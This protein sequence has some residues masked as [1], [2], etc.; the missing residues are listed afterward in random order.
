M[1]DK[2]VNAT[3]EPS[4]ARGIASRQ[5]VT[6][7]MMT[8]LVDSVRATERER[9]AKI[10]EEEKVDAD[11]TGEDSDRAYNAACDHI[12]ARIRETT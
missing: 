9:C 4:E 1:P 7:K 5:I 12:A 8:Q 6:Q 2:P 11:A 10:A 3:V